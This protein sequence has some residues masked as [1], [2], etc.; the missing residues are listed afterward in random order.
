MTIT[1]IEPVEGSP[2]MTEPV[3]GGDLTLRCPA[4]DGR[5]GVTLEGRGPDKAHVDCTACGH[6]F[7]TEEMLTAM[8][9]S[10]N[11]VIALARDR[12]AGFKF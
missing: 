6:H 5:F 12:L 8:A 2:I 1:I 7:T 4:C 11:D 3:G 10:L 9:E